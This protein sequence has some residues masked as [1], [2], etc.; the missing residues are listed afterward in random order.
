M[1]DDWPQVKWLALMTV[2][3]LCALFLFAAKP[4]ASHTF[5]V[6]FPVA[7]LYG[8]YCWDSLLRRRPWRVFALVFLACGVVFHAGLAAH[9]FPRVSLYAN[10]RAVQAAIDEKNPSLLG[11]RRPGSLY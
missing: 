11:E 8:F 7:A 6:T 2:L 9:N 3:L 1:P 4:P 5:Y 10:R